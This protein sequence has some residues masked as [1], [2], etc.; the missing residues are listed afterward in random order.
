MKEIGVRDLK[1][2]LSQVLRRI[3]DGEQ[4]RVTLRGRHVADL[5]PAGTR[6]SDEQLRQLVADGRVTP[7]SRP[8]PKVRPRPV[9]TG[10]S[11]TAIVLDERNDDR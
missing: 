10:R 11:A 7:A 1:A 6:R 8:R 5:V 2:N 9:A 3:D 4:V